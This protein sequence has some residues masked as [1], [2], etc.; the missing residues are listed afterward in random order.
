[1]RERIILSSIR[2]AKDVKRSDEVEETPTYSQENIQHAHY[3]L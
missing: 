3:L 1:V 2:V